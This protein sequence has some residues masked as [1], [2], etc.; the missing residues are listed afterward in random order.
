MMQSKSC[1]PRKSQLT[2]HLVGSKYLVSKAPAVANFLT[3]SRKRF[4]R[5]VLGQ[6]QNT[7]S[8]ES[9]TAGQTLPIQYP[10]QNSDDVELIEVKIDARDLQNENAKPRTFP[11]P[12]GW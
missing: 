9:H 8:L 10:L 12:R 1:G 5:A 2:T 6:K 4:S 7:S 11:R 3:L